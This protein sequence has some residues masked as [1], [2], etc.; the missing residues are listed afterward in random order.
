MNHAAQL[1]VIIGPRRCIV[2]RALC[3]LLLASGLAQPA[4]AQAPYPAKPVR[5]IVAFPPGGGNDVAGRL[6][7]QKLSERL[8]QSVVVEN[9]AGAN[10]IVG[11]QALMQS[12][13]DGYTLGVGAAG[14]MAVKP[15]IYAKLPYDP[16][17]DF[18]PI[19]NVAVF[20]LL[21]VTHPS[22][23][24]KTLGELLALARER[25][26]ELNYASPGVGNS[27]H[28]AGELLNRMAGVRITHVAYKGQGPAITDLL[29]G[30]VQMLWASIPSVIG[31]IQSGKLNAIAIGT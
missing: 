22:L 12:A 5:I 17:K 18:T 23:P 29:A 24:A 15:S 9:R 25:P 20:P 16:L 6:V 27:G 2:R 19:S 4:L 8:G 11:L 3:L 26:G 1:I 28:L 31:H 30:Q 10:G 14:P 13:P 21:L 7:A